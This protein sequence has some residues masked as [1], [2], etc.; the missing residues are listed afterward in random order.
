MCLPTLG[1][2][3]GDSVIGPPI[4]DIAL[5]S[6]R[7]DETDATVIHHDLPHAATEVLSR[8]RPAAS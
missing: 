6:E 5:I 7:E 8:W 2:V 1:H 3:D 4:A